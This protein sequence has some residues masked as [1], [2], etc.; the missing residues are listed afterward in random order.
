MV[1]AFTLVELLLT[2]LGVGVVVIIVVIGIKASKA[3]TDI[4]IKNNIK[5]ACAELTRPTGKGSLVIES[6]KMEELGLVD[7]LTQGF[8][9]TSVTYNIEWEKVKEGKCRYRYTATDGKNTNA[10][11]WIDLKNC[12]G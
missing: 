5:C 7:V 9:L 1:L 2:I 12:P 10:T 6:M 4:G 11:E 3:A 8:T